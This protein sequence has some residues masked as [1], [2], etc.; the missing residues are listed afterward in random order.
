MKRLSLIL[1]SSTLLSFLCV[2]FCFASPPQKTETSTAQ[3]TKEASTI[4]HATRY[5]ASSLSPV[6]KRINGQMHHAIQGAIKHARKDLGPLI[7]FE[8][9][10]IK[11]LR[12]NKEVA[13]FSI[14]PPLIYQQLKV[15]GHMAFATVIQLNRTD[16]QQK[17]LKEWAQSFQ[18]D[19]LLLRLELPKI[20]LSKEL[21]KSQDLLI[22]RTLTLLK[23]VE[24]MP[25]TKAMLQQYS[26]EIMPYL[27]AGIKKSARAQVDWLHTQT[28]KIYALLTQEERSQVR[29]HLYGGRGARVGNINIQYLSWLFGEGTGKESGRIIFSENIA[30]HNRALDYFARYTTERMLADLIFKD[31]TQLDRDLLSEQ[32]RIYLSTFGDASHFVSNLPLPKSPEK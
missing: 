13:A 24:L 5:S 25:I 22:Q 2:H 4:H 29:A 6:M 11:L 19:L 27:Q 8:A 26:I 1:I 9:G 21:E 32:T 28:Q 14:S 7:I 23:N 10:H 30:D 16:L 3:K 15:L 31:P 17:E 20:G 18:A 12:K